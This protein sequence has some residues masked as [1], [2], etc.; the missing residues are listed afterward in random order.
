MESYKHSCPFCGQHIEYT[1][2]YCGKQMQCPS[3]GK[4]VAFPAIPPGQGR[5]APA[6]HVKVLDSSRSESG[7]ARRRPGST[8][9]ALAFLRGFQHWNVVAQCALPF[10]IIGLLLAGAFFVK[11]KFNDAPAP[12][13]SPAV[14]ADPE[15]WQRIADLAKADQAVRDLIKEYD[16]DRLAVASAERARQQMQKGDPLQARSVEEQVELAHSKLDALHK[17]LDNA[18]EKYRQLGGNVDY[19]RQ[20]RN[21]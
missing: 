1:V 5:G 20:L 13:T 4:S 21:Y 15:A 3:C 7:P 17:R 14:Q 6:A 8:P 18:L 16:A 11:S 12:V 9:K 10:L 19:R 2:G